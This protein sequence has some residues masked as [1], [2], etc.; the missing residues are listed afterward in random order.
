MSEI[1][2]IKHARIGGNK[3]SGRENVAV[4]TKGAKWTF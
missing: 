2:F 3:T 1:V 4:K